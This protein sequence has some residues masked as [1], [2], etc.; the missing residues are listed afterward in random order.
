[1]N[2]HILTWHRAVVS[3][4][5]IALLG[6]P[7]LGRPGQVPNALE[8]NWPDLAAEDA[9]LAY[10][11]IWRLAQNPEAAEKLLKERMK[12]TEAPDLAQIQTWVTDLSS[13]TFAV[14]D[15]A[16]RELMA[17]GELAEQPLRKALEGQIDLE[18]RRRLE[19]LINKIEQPVTAPEKIRELRAVEALEI[20]G[21]D[22]AKELLQ[23]L[24]KGYSAHRQ[25]RQ[26]QES[27]QRL[28]KR[29]P[30]PAEWLAWIKNP[31]PVI[32]TDN[33]LPFGA[34][35]RLGTLGFRHQSPGKAGAYSSA[36]SPDG[37]RVISHDLNAV[38]V[39]ETQTG[40]LQRKFNFT[41][42][43]L[44]AAP[45]DT[46]AAVGLTLKDTKSGAVICLDW[47][48]GKELSRWE[49][50]AGVTPRQ[51]AFSPDGAKI[52]C[53]RSDNSLC[54]WDIKSGKETTL[55]QPAGKLRRTP[56]SWLLAQE[57][58]SMFSISKRN[59]STGSRPWTANRALRRFR[60]TTS[61]WPLPRTVRASGYTSA[62][63]PLENSFRALTVE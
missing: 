16:N 34:R 56:P 14:R 21:T 49:L 33:P 7:G 13:P 29:A 43:C 11:A 3:L 50:P 63:S 62:K 60:L 24:A 1:M 54:E 12:A 28:E 53:D 2:P 55:W 45:K 39:W 31:P 36:F 25:T 9:E 19:L 57:R 58:T 15:K 35:K 42:S 20:M 37:R 10:R 47:Q 52:F 61:L 23:R 17:Q 59:K 44:A 48:N 22:Q 4:Y 30:A 5:F 18:T 38:Y 6:S 41:A 27:L 26:A 46:L 32:G 8:K 51:L 40:N